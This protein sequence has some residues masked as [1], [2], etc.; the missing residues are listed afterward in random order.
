MTVRKAVIR[1]A[2]RIL[3]LVE[4]DAF[5]PSGVIRKIR[6]QYEA[7]RNMGV[8]AA[9]VVVSPAGGVGQSSLLE[10]PGIS[11]VTHGAGRFGT[12]KLL[13]AVAIQRAK[14]I[15]ESFS[16]DL[17][18]YR[19]SSWTPGVMSVLKL[20]RAVVAEINSNDTTEVH[21]YGWAKARYHLA[22]RQML[23]RAVDGFVCVGKD[24]QAVYCGYGKPV[25]LIGNGFDLD[26]VRPREIPENTRPQLV[27]VG[28]AGQAWHGL[29][30]ILLMA[31][32]LK[33]CDFHIVGDLVHDAPSNVRS[34]G[35]VGWDELDKIYRKMDFGIASLALHRIGVNEITP[36]KT[37]EYLAYG[38]PVIGAYDD[39][40]LTG[41]DFFL[42]LPNRECGVSESLG[43]IRS[44]VA[45]WHRRAIDREW[46]RGR[47]DSAVKERKR[48]DFMFD[49][50][51]T[52][53]RSA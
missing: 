4:W 39:T 16:P 8:N 28:S 44:F 26:S 17:I 21:Q 41:C 40:D 42:R 7:W 24:V 52:E 37:R 48:V 2:T 47:I 9:L 29:D 13:K 38:L 45:T 31:A 18:Y 3:Y 15:V 1:E 19:Q 50:L 12:G 53:L 25:A 46:V 14:A 22:T 51:N 43:A 30:Q 20:A 34:Y 49:M 33:E 27:F 5:K 23:V 11:V 6:A 32:E 35:H 36:L 10:G